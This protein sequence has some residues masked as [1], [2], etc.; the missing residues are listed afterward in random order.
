MSVSKQNGV[1]WTLVLAEVSFIRMTFLA[2]VGLPDPRKDHAIVMV[3]QIPTFLS[4]SKRAPFLTVHLT[5]QAKFA[6]DCL[7]KFRS[8]TRGMEKEL[9]PDTSE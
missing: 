9:G 6:R 4:F 1:P 8:L 2:V 3:S 5:V 7:Y